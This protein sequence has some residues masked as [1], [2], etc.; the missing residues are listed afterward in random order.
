[1]KTFD[2]VLAWLLLA[3]G[4]LHTTAS[5]ALMSRT[6][7]LDSAWFFAGGLAVIF[8]AFLNLIRT[9]RPTDSMIARTS[10]LANLLLLILSLLLCWVL[11]HDLKRNPQAAVF[12]PL[13]ALELLFSVRQWLR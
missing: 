6:L 8:G 10:V 2:R 5:V 13:I 11:R 7:N 12:V 9:Y 3:F 1:M 4:L